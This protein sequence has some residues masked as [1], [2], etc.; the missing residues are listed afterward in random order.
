VETRTPSIDIVLIEDDA[1][2]A[3]LIQDILTIKGYSVHYTLSPKTGIDDAIRFCPKLVIVD[4]G[5]PMVS[6][7]DVIGYL[8]DQGVT[9]K[10]M[11]I[12]GDIEYG[13]EKGEDI[14]IRKPFS[15]VDFVKAIRELIGNPSNQDAT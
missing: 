7:T 3:G 5:L 2:I 15:I 1:T 10:I 12:T 11:L 13:G 6:G 9:S 14:F 4:K 8:R